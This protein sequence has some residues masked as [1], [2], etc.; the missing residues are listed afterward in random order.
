MTAQE[1]KERKLMVVLRC[2][3]YFDDAFTDYDSEAVAFGGWYSTV[4]RWIELE[5]AWNRALKEE[6][7]HY[8]H[9]T[10]LDA[11]QGEFVGWTKERADS[12]MARLTT[13]A[14]E[15][16]ECAVGCG[17]VRADYERLF[18][19]WLQTDFKHPLNY[20]VY[21]TMALLVTCNT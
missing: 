4:E 15:F 13:I 1:L 9:A 10:D 17:I 18:P 8:F 19:D 16:T 2:Q 12:F 11:R 5:S 6:G 14:A 7:I 3:L 21:G 20:C